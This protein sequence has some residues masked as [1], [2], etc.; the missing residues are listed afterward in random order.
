MIKG[1]QR[2]EEVWGHVIAEG[3][4]GAGSWVKCLGLKEKGLKRALLGFG[5]FKRGMERFQEEKQRWQ[6]YGV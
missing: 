1:R 6:G 4:M 5:G 2:V 3:L